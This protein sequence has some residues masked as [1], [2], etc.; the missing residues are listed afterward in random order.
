MNLQ[1]ILLALT[2]ILY[3]CSDRNERIKKNPALNQRLKN[4]HA[5][6]YLHRKL[7]ATTY[8][9]EDVN[10]TVIDEASLKK[11][12]K[13]Y[14]VGKKKRVAFRYSMPNIQQRNGSYYYQIKNATDTI[15]FS[16]PSKS[17][18]DEI[19]KT[20]SLD[21]GDHYYVVTFESSS[22][23]ESLI[24]GKVSR[25]INAYVLGVEKVETLRD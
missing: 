19:Q 15:R 21:K 13:Y 11:F 23:D 1:I 7:L 12:N 6:M 14:G 20:S 18:H 4:Y 22:I 17:L 9:S 8:P 3:S 25:I 5:Q 24:K 16:S 2:I 10:L